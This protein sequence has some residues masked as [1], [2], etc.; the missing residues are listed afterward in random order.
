MA[1]SSSRAPFSTSSQPSNSLRGAVDGAW[2]PAARGGV[3]PVVV[4]VAVA[5]GSV[6]TESKS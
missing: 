5:E 3:G 4:A 1:V 6:A 2:W